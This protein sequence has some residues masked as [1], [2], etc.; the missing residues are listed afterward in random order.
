MSLS[1]KR[2]LKGAGE[3]NDLI[4]KRS[5][6]L[7]TWDFKTDY[8]DHFETPEQAY[9]DLLPVLKELAGAL[10]KPLSELIVYD[11]YYCL[12][13]MKQHLQSLGV[14]SVINE[15][16]DFYKGIQKKRIP[17]ISY[18]ELLSTSS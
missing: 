4:I 3:T 12:G 9:K 7:P 6:I 17:G 5:K 11:P 10:N 2:A 18:D 1:K 15:N 8:N 14:P 13:N 16:K